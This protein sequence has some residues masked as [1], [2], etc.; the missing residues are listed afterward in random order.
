ML[1]I[2]RLTDYG[3]LIMTH[4]ARDSGRLFAA[5]EIALAVG[6]AQPT[7]TKLL[8]MLARSG[9]LESRRGI[10]GGYSLARAPSE[11]SMG[12]VISALEGPM[13]L[14]DCGTAS[15]PRE[16]NRGESCSA[17]AN[18]QRISQAVSDALDSVS[19]AEMAQPS[20]TVQVHRRPISSQGL[21][22]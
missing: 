20:Q 22:S 5:Q 13:G 15:T 19:L 14:T 18:W 6:V 10:H 17:R 1:K 3:T 21:H 2:G 4:M 7:A 12:E 9:L 11:I 16:C 8:K